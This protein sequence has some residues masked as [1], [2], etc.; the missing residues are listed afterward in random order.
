M[1]LAT[2]DRASNGVLWPLPVT[3]DMAFAD[4]G[5][6]ACLTMLNVLTPL[7]RLASCALPR[8]AGTWIPALDQLGS[9]SAIDNR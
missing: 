7:M 8:G 2:A 9:H 5:V 3:I 6:K 4:T 1:H